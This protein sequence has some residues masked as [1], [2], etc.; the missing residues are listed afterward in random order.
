MKIGHERF[1]FFRSDA[2]IGHIALFIFVPRIQD[3]ARFST[4]IY[5]QNLNLFRKLY[6]IVYLFLAQKRAIH[7]GTPGSRFNIPI[8]DD[9]DFGSKWSLP[10]LK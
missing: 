5:N 6:R 9:D 2:L 4:T 1:I 3:T 8:V 7:I 10:R